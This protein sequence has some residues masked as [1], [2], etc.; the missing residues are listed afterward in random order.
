[1]Q[2]EEEFRGGTRPDINKNPDVE[3]PESYV[4]RAGPR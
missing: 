1:M 3:L 4:R 2:V